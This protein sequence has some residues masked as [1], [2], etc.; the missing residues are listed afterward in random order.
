M[1]EDDVSLRLRLLGALRFEHDANRAARS[2]DNIGDQAAQASRK[3]VGLNAASSRTRLSIGP[4]STSM[5]GG[6]LAVGA[7]T[8]ATGKAVP[9]V[10]SAAEAVAT[11]AGGAGAAGGVGML[12]LAQATGVAKLG[13]SDMTK[14]LGGNAQAAKR[15][16]PEIRDLFDT[17]HE[18]QKLLQ[19]T[20]QGSMLPGLAQGA[21]SASRNFGVLRS[22][23]GDTGRTLGGLGK[24][25][26]GLLGSGRFGRDLRTVGRGNVQIINNLGHAGLF[27]ADS[28]RHIAVE[29]TPLTVWL[30]ESARRGAGIVDTWA[31]TARASG[32]MARFFHEARVDMALL[33]SLSGH[34][35]RGLI[36][37]FGAQDVNGTRTLRNLDQ[38][39]ARFER[40]SKSPAVLRN[41]GDAVI[42]EIPQAVAAAMDAVARNLPS[43]GAHAARVFV[44][45]F[46]A[47][48]VWGK[49]LGGSFLVAKFGG[50]KALRKLLLGGGG[51]LGGGGLIGKATP[52]P[53]FV[54]N[55][56]WGGKPGTPVPTGGPGRRALPRALRL[57]GRLAPPVAAAVALGELAQPY[58]GNNN[59]PTR[60]IDP[61]SRGAS[62]HVG[63][64]AN[65]MDR[66]PDRDVQV[67]NNTYVDGNRVE[68]SRKVVTMRQLARRR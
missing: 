37:L 28:L 49:L 30:S 16:T 52:V 43:A 66:V 41:V 65:A 14:A 45:S 3:I 57:A 18:K 53:V 40:W 60:G 32:Q 7:F 1:P 26:G 63:F 34:T 12:A 61:A 42:A 48:D 11:L 58:A 10:L 59:F 13:L 54:T 29:A 50:F 36:N 33:G 47:A 27:L 4:F 15:L 2:I 68:H 24:D 39:T 35:G 62:G 25:A 44:E 6:A 19:S 67:I 64:N 22:I 55:P 8:L 20:A 17:L 51:G 5:R 56:G 38:L 21:K 31:Q 46:I 23:V 9:T